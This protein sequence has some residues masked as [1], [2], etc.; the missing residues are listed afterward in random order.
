MFRITIAYWY[1]CRQI[2]RKKRGFIKVMLEEEWPKSFLNE[3]KNELTK[4]C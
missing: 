4:K 2:Y 1:T 3:N